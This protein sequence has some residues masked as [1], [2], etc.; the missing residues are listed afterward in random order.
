MRHTHTTKERFSDFIKNIALEYKIDYIEQPSAV[1]RDNEITLKFKICDFSISNKHIS[2][3]IKDISEIY[4][5]DET[6]H[7]FLHKI[8]IL[9]DNEKES[10]YETWQNGDLEYFLESIS[11]LSEIDDKIIEEIGSILESI[12]ERYLTCSYTS[13]EKNNEE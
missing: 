2:K 13:E 10:I 9:I 1:L 3:E 7:D 11:D 4:E 8:A 12:E 6:V 5:D